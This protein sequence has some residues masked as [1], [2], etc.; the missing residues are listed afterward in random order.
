MEL[1]KKLEE[2]ILFARKKVDRLEYEKERLNIETQYNSAVK[3]FIPLSSDEKR[4][5]ARKYKGPLKEQLREI[6]RDKNGTLLAAVIG[7]IEGSDMRLD[8]EVR[9]AVLDAKEA[10]ISIAR[11][12]ERRRKVK[13][14]REGT[15][16]KKEPPGGK[17]RSL[18]TP[19]TREKAIAYYRL[20]MGDKAWEELAKT[21][22]GR[23]KQEELIGK[24]AA[25]REI[26]HPFRPIWFLRQH[27]NVTWKDELARGLGIIAMWVSMALAIIFST[28]IC[29]SF[30]DFPL[31]L[32]L[33]PEG[34][35]DFG[36]WIALIAKPLLDTSYIQAI[37]YGYSIGIPLAIAAN[38]FTHRTYNILAVKYG[39][40]MLAGDVSRKA[41]TAQKPMETDAAY[42]ALERIRE[43]KNLENVYES[44]K[45]LTEQGTLAIGK[46]AARAITKSGQYQEEFLGEFITASALSKNIKY[47]KA[48]EMSVENFGSEIDCVIEVDRARYSG[49]TA[50]RSEVEDGIYLVESKTEDRSTNIDIVIEQMVGDREEFVK[51][52]RVKTK[53]DR[54]M[55][56]ALA[57]RKAGYDVK[58][59]IFAVNGDAVQEEGIQQFKLTQLE[60]GTA[61]EVMAIGIYA[62]F[63]PDVVIKRDKD[64]LSRRERNLAEIIVSGLRDE[65]KILE[66]EATEYETVLKEAMIEIGAQKTREAI[67]EALRAVGADPYSHSRQTRNHWMQVFE[68]LKRTPRSLTKLLSVAPIFLLFSGQYTG[69]GIALT[70]GMMAFTL[71]MSIY[72][73]GR[74]GKKA[75]AD[76]D[77]PNRL[78][79]DWP[80]VLKMPKTQEMAVRSLAAIAS[81]AHG[82]NQDTDLF[83]S[84]QGVENYCYELERIISAD[85]GLSPYRTQ[86]GE[87]HGIALEATEILSG[88]YAQ[89]MYYLQ[90]HELPRNDKTEQWRERFEK[91]YMLVQEAR[92]K[93]DALI[94]AVAD[95][96]KLADTEWAWDEFN[97][98][99]KDRMRL[100]DGAVSGESFD[101]TGIMNNL[102]EHLSLTASGQNREYI[103]LRIPTD[104][105]PT[106]ITGNRRS[107]ISLITNVVDN[108][109]K[110]AHNYKKGLAKVIVELRRD[111]DDAVIIVTDNGPGISR[112]KINE[113]QTPFYTT[114]GTGIGLT[115]ARVIAADHRATISVRPRE[116]AGS[117]FIIR[118]PV[119]ITFG[120]PSGGMNEQDVRAKIESILTEKPE[121]RVSAEALLAYLEENHPGILEA[122]ET[123]DKKLKYIVDSN[124]VSLTRLDAAP[125]LIT[126]G[127]KNAASPDE[128]TK[129]TVIAYIQEHYDEV[130]SPAKKAWLGSPYSAV[131]SAVG[132]KGRNLFGRSWPRAVK[133]AKFDI[134]K[135]GGSRIET[136]P[137]EWT[138]E[139]VIQ[140]IKAHYDEVA[141]SSRNAWLASGYSAAVS[142]V[143]K[144]EKGLFNGSWTKA[145]EAAGY[146]RARIGGPRKTTSPPEWTEETAKAY[147]RE[148]Y[149]EVGSARQEDWVNSEYSAVVSA[150]YSTRYNMFDR[151]WRKF[152]MAV[153]HEPV[154][155]GARKIPVSE[156]GWTEEK[157]KLY[158]QAHHDEVG[159][160]AEKDWKDSPFAD[161]VKAVRN[162]R[163]NLFSGSWQQ[164]IIRSGYKP[165][166]V[167][168]K[169]AEQLTTKSFSEG[170]SPAG[171]P[172]P[173]DAYIS[174]YE[175]I[176]IY[177]NSR[178]ATAG[179]LSPDGTELAYLMRMALPKTENM[180]PKSGLSIYVHVVPEVEGSV[181]KDIASSGEVRLWFD[182]AFV[183]TLLQ[184]RGRYPDAIPWL[185][186]E[187]L[188]HELTH[189]NKMGTDKEEAVEERDVILKFDLPFYRM[190]S[191]AAELKREVDRFFDETGTKFG[192]R[193]Y[194]KRLLAIIKDMP[195]AS[196]RAEIER[197]INRYYNFSFKFPEPK[198]G[199][200]PL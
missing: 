153:G 4:R 127:R 11:K 152:V 25:R 120:G 135:K 157:A 58:G 103:D 89:A 5:Q 6:I 171:K 130:G 32:T 93:K 180:V 15:A 72:G 107:I 147:F 137:A 50:G 74:E 34:R 77:I 190:L 154:R 183:N 42:I 27:D 90:R 33:S 44:I 189:D 1:R 40:G 57:M 148:H 53:L 139:S 99:S 167:G 79:E 182:E 80:L 140:Y 178:I 67:M 82:T 12:I 134:A 199:Q 181:K 114:G 98:I 49:N 151:D 162:P 108:A 102:F 198:R 192:G 56:N 168:R 136:S 160:S 47:S 60:K 20:R 16:E 185:L 31:T 92:P 113:M 85:L 29:S 124:P 43:D 176:A 200:T 70:L 164:A 66:Q 172:M 144:K 150:I 19:A 3:L 28:V 95:C 26:F 132:Y 68:A 100:I 106:M 69:L 87:L 187:R 81:F 141:S 59:L 61:L 126:D 133:A 146:S 112:E 39:F 194:F 104:P 149:E 179:N 155:I 78:P 191:R 65:G 186:A 71:G 23:R 83:A 109:C 75:A 169:S 36:S 105:A 115:E 96:G 62:A 184:Y 17:S 174:S 195:E 54:Y 197:F 55:L 116:G 84:I 175:G 51:G 76:A 196:A 129:K 121:L 193:R 125:S 156:T 63:I 128:W 111:G 166:Q 170:V 173:Q 163:Y 97:E 46:V 48:L 30:L 142:A 2:A 118:I 188:G 10:V 52:K 13:E 138:E 45:H 119:S 9:Q 38:W 145:I 41:R 122:F 117:Q 159:S 14:K 91:A 161:V 88:I 143:E 101:L 86:A 177:D 22:E 8:A 110:Y 24:Y 73:N 158:I 7:R 18:A 35:G 123:R 131:V 94:A 21:D 165:A 37:P 64:G